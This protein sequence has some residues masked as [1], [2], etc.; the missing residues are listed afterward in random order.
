MKKESNPPPP[1]I[2]H[3]PKPPTSPPK[4]KYKS[5]RM[6]YYHLCIQCGREFQGFKPQNTCWCCITQYCKTKGWI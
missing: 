5:K 2:K 6:N 1:D 4:R 3:K